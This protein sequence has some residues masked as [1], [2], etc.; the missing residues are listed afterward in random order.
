MVLLKAEQARNKNMTV[1]YFPMFKISPAENRASG[2]LI[3]I[4]RRADT[5]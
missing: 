3:T 5:Y 4:L 2:S 1:D